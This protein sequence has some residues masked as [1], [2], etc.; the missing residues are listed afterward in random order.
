MHICK[1]DA[2]GWEHYTGLLGLVP[3]KNGVSERPLTPIEEVRIGASIRLV[4][5][6]SNEQVGAATV[7]AEA[8]NISAAS[9]PALQTANEEPAR[10]VELKYTKDKLE[11]IASEGGIK[12]VREIAKEFDVKGVEISKMIEDI[13]KVQLGTKEEE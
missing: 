7:M 10:E 8:R 4:R 11:E 2:V 13:M 12:A 9:A 5:V 6:E 1:I 3:F